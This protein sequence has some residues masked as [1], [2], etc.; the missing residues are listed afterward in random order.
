[1]KNC[2]LERKKNK[3]LHLY[4]LYDG[5]KHWYSAETEEEA[6][7]MH[8]N[9]IGDDYDYDC[10]AWGEMSPDKVLSVRMDDGQGTVEK[11]ASE[12]AVLGKGF[13]ASTVY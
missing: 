5:E 8:L 3:N 12:W 13:V 1:M 4:K 2:W 10:L 6:V 9:H 7:K 11:T